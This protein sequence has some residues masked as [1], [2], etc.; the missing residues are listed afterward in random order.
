MSCETFTTEIDGNKY[1]YTQLSATNSLT[2]KFE[3]AGIAGKAI[4]DLVPHMGESSDKQIK[5]FGEALSDIFKVN[6]PEKV[7]NLI[8]RIMVPAF[9][10]GK[11]IEFDDDFTGNMSEMYNVLLWILKKEFGDFLGGVESMIK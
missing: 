3:L 4:A 6:D 11:R 1:A 2:L 7:V 9:R 5:A 8:K 10:N